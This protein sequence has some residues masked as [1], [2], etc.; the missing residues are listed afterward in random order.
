MAEREPTR[1]TA[2]R[3][4]TK[5]AKENTYRTSFFRHDYAV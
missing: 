3:R 1:S 5:H 2:L 4:Q